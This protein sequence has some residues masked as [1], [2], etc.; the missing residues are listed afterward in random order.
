MLNY[1]RTCKQLMHVWSPYLS[2]YS[3]VQ[4]G[5]IRWFH[6]HHSV[7]NLL[8]LASNPTLF[9]HTNFLVFPNPKLGGGNSQICLVCYVHP[10]FPENNDPQFWQTRIFFKWVGEKPPTRMGQ[11]FVFFP[12]KSTGWLV[13]ID[14]KCI[15][16]FRVFNFDTSPDHEHIFV[17]IG[18]IRASVQNFYQTS[19]TYWPWKILLLGLVPQ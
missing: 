13:T 15:G 1:R 14:Q 19:S 12:H 10:R 9:S 3:A 11:C 8:G 17:M 5:T 6:I 16:Y 2:V 7:C 4:E 18:N